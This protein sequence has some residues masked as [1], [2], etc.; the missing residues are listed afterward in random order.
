MATASSH[1]AAL[2]NG[3]GDWLSSNLARPR[4]SK[5]AAAI[6][7]RQPTR[8]DNVCGSQSPIFSLMLALNIFDI[9]NGCHNRPAEARSAVAGPC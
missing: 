6:A 7:G 9:S 5:R 2:A 8:A 1:S 4:E 3:A